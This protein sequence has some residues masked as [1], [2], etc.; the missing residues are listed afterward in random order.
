MQCT[1][2]IECGRNKKRKKKRNRAD[3]VKFPRKKK[4]GRAKKS[5]GFQMGVYL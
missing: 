1:A 2:G 4:T 5:L 3:S